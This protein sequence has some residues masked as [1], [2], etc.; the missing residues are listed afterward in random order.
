MWKWSGNE[1]IKCQLICC[2]VTFL[3]FFEVLL[4]CAEQWYHGLMQQT[5]PP[6]VPP[7][8]PPAVG[9]GEREVS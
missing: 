2:Q 3:E 5:V 4:V 9:E 7:A 6:T 1:A 8:V